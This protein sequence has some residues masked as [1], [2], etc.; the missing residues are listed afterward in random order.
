MIFLYKYLCEPPHIWE[1]VV[2]LKSLSE[3]VPLAFRLDFGKVRVKPGAYNISVHKMHV[4]L[5][6][7]TSWCVMEAL[8]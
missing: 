1:H 3:R 4:T 7:L 2:N 5:G 8:Q 6:T